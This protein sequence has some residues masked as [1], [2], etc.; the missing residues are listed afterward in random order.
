MVHCTMT[1]TEEAISLSKVT[2]GATTKLLRQ[3]SKRVS[4]R[5]SDRIREA[6]QVFVDGALYNG[7]CERGN[8]TLKDYSRCHDQAVVTSG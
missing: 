7:T 3:A 2:P 1:P 5:V 4:E 6:V 8:I